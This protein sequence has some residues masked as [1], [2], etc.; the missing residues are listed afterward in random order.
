MGQPKP[1]RIQT[2]F[3]LGVA[4]PLLFYRPNGLFIWSIMQK[5]RTHILHFL[6]SAAVVS[7]MFLHSTSNT[8][9]LDFSS[10]ASEGFITFKSDGTASYHAD[11]PTFTLNS[12]LNIMPP[13]PQQ[14]VREAV[15][16]QARVAQLNSN[17]LAGNTKTSCASC[18]LGTSQKPTVVNN[19][20][21]PGKDYIEKEI[22]R[23]K[24][25][26]KYLFDI[27]S[28]NNQSSPF[29]SCIKSSLSN[30]G[31]KV[32]QCDNPS[33]RLPPNSKWGIK[34]CVSEEGKYIDLTVNS[35]ELAS[36]CL[37]PYLNGQSDE[38]SIEKQKGALFTLLNHESGFHINAVSPTGAAGI[39]QFITDGIDWVNKFGWNEVQE[40]I[41]GSDRQSCKKIA[42]MKLNKMSSSVANSCER[43]SLSKQQPLSGLVYTF[44][45]KKM[46][47]KQLEK[48]MNANSYGQK[49]LSSL[50]SENKEILLRELSNWGHNTGSNGITRPFEIFASSNRGRTLLAA[51]DVKKFLAEL[52]G[53][54]Y[55]YTKN[56]LSKNL[57]EPSPAKL[58]KI[59]NRAKEASGFYGNIHRDLKHLEQYV[60]KSCNINADGAQ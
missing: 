26:N 20:C 11:V 43:I 25:S 7:V 60:G 37:S 16:V 35:F 34:A 15:Q 19:T 49:S 56:M 44:V 59:E 48:V 50:S 3:N 12:T 17:Q 55:S 40:Y 1:L 29:R 2:N 6:M 47:R 33:G 42:D 38:K 23:N 9:T 57:V 18:K 22:E 27:L 36:E 53:V 58:Q 51:G 4:Y 5:A 39:G 54:V 32:K 30:F 14:V 10:N 13:T 41:G 45:H 31:A 46:I 24:D 52:K 8:S 28:I 21:A